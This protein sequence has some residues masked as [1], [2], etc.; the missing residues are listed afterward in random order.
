M[1]E[2][3]DYDFLLQLAE[4]DKPD[5]FSNSNKNLPSLLQKDDDTVLEEAY[6]RRNLLAHVAS[7]PDR[8]KSQKLTAVSHPASE[9]CRTLKQT[10]KVQTEGQK[11]QKSACQ[12]ACYEE[13]LSGLRVSHPVVGSLVVRDRLSDGGGPFMKLSQLSCSIG[14]PT[15]SLKGSPHVWTTVVI[16][17]SKSACEGRD[18]SSYGR[19]QVTDF[20]STTTLFL[21]GQAQKELYKECEGS[22]YIL[23]NAKYSKESGGGGYGRPGFSLTVDKPQQVQRIGS[24]PDLGKCSGT[25]KDGTRCSVPVNRS[26]CEYCIYHAQT[27]LRKLNMTG[28]RPE[29]VAGGRSY[30]TKAIQ[31]VAKRGP[32]LT[33]P[34]PRPL[35][36][37]RAG[38]GADLR[39][40]MTQRVEQVG[41]SITKRNSFRMML[42][43][44][45]Q[46]DEELQHGCEGISSSSSK[47]LKMCQEEGISE[48]K[49]RLIAH[50]K[51]VKAT[52]VANLSV[53]Q[54][55]RQVLTSTMQ[56]A[57]KENHGPA[58][59]LVRD[60]N[61][62]KLRTK[63][64]PSHQVG[65]EKSR[66]TMISIIVG[67]SGSYSDAQPR[68]ASHQDAQ[69]RYS[70]VG[71]A[72]YEG[73]VSENEDDELEIVPECGDDADVSQLHDPVVAVGSTQV[74]ALITS[75]DLQAGDYSSSSIQSASQPLFDQIPEGRNCDEGSMIGI[76]SNNIG[77]DSVG[78]EVDRALL[79]QPQVNLRLATDNNAVCGGKLLMS[80]QQHDDLEIVAD[81]EDPEEGH[82]LQV[83]PEVSCSSRGTSVRAWAPV[84]IRSKPEERV[85][86]ITVHNANQPGCRLVPGRPAALWETPMSSEERE[87]KKEAESR[88]DASRK[89][90]CKLKLIKK[91][92]LSAAAQL[93]KPAGLKVGSRLVKKPGNVMQEQSQKQLKEASVVRN[94]SMLGKT[95]LGA[96]LGCSAMEAAF[97]SLR[98]VGLLEPN[99]CASRYE[100][101]AEDADFEA[102]KKRMEEYEKKEA[103]MQKLDSV[104]KIAVQAWHCTTCKKF[105]ET[106][107]PGCRSH[108]Q[109]RVQTIKRFWICCHC[110]AHFSSLGVIH[111]TTRCPRC[112]DHGKDF[113]PATM[114]SGAKTSQPNAHAAL[115]ERHNF[116]AR[117]TEHRF[118]LK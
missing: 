45:Q 28:S 41:S 37:Q 3:D 44:A 74:Q 110:N 54:A 90:L 117:G 12:T 104:T 113:K 77:N 53:P 60:V 115:A 89:V 31:Q 10:A 66:S 69:E 32:D 47:L 73:R 1:D 103:L 16:L 107:N 8:S 5:N 51:N 72:F 102:T 71:G 50:V 108:G 49:A 38:S 99:K 42:A 101:I 98:S 114:Y 100:D 7:L 52:P 23:Y 84:A 57:D 56:S 22:V 34:S 64:V 65:I 2:E 9:I 4:F 67:D 25:K 83:L 18:G 68:P 80:P 46:R 118:S 86:T 20:T 11:V 6:G 76:V 93:I 82:A 14:P 70:S 105:T 29:L 27:A 109:T 112:N 79:E 62:R 116:Q 61:K 26:E 55:A 17:G 88:S 30:T 97:G 59:S 85:N 92:P 95:M 91:Q 33:R 43:V 15:S 21:F 81:G 96:G 13:K 87:A 111:P 75:E 40:R 19:W 58:A 63:N 35:A 78:T 24:S 106:F 39:G 36:P 94:D 48:A